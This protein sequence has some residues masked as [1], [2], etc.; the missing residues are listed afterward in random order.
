MGCVVWGPSIRA[1]DASFKTRNILLL[2]V[3][4]H[5]T[6]TTAKP[7]ESTTGGRVAMRDSAT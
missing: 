2:R 5:G 1:D 6:H 4:V 3:F 7:D